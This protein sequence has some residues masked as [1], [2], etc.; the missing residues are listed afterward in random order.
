M[1]KKKTEDMGEFDTLVGPGTRV[2]GNLTVSGGVHLEGQVR[3]NVVTQ[4]GSKA[5]L[6]IADRGVVEGLV[7]V[8]RVVV[9]GEVKGDIRAVEKVELGAH[10]RIAGNVYYGLIEMAAGAQ[11]RGRLIAA[12]PDGK[13]PEAS[14]TP[15]TD[16][17]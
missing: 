9:H 13:A 11:I 10:A 14:P 8:A 3:G 7:D 16:T 12:D 17:A 4:E 15:P 6:F 5:W 2:D 1:F